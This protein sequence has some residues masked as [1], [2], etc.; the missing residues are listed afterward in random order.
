MDSNRWDRIQSVF[1]G[2]ADLPKSQQRAFLVTACADDESLIADIQ[3]LLDEDAKDSSLLNRKM[4]DVASEVLGDSASRPFPFKEFGPYRIMRVLGE[5][6]MGVVFLAERRDLHSQV[7]IKIL[8]DAWVS[9]ARRERF[10]SEQRT[11]AQLNHPSIAR[12]YDADTLPDGTPL[13]VM[14]Y[15]EGCSIV[16]YCKKLNSSI[17]DRLKLF[18][19]V[20][21]A[22]EYAHSQAVIHRDLKPSNILVKSDG[23]V[24]LLDFGIAKQLED[25]NV[26]ADATRTSFRFLTPAYASPEQIR[27]D[28]VGIQSDVYSLGVILYEL[29]CNQLPFDLSSKTPTEAQAAIL[30]NE[31]VK[32]SFIGQRTASENVA[33]SPGGTGS[34]TKAAWTDLDVLCLTAMHKDPQRRYRSVEALIRDIDHYLRGEP[35]EA[36]PDSVLYRMDKFVGRNR[37]TV[38]ASALVGALIVGLVIF[39]TLRLAKARNAALAETARTLRVEQFMQDLFQGDAES[40]GPADDLRVVTVLERGEKQ[41]RALDEDPEIQA[42][43]YQTLGTM[44]DQLG[45][46]DRADSLLKASLAQ[47]KAIDGADSA[48]VAESLVALANLR[49][50]QAQLAEAE[51]FARQGLQMSKRHLPPDH[52]VVA[53]A[54]LTLGR[55]LDNRGKYDEAIPTLEEAMRLESGPKGVPADL[56]A[57]LS[58]LANTHYYLGHYDVSKDLN[59]RALRMDEQI[60][61]DRNPN[62]AQDL[63]NLADIQYQWSNYA[64]AERLQRTAVGIMQ[65]W[66]GKDH[67]ETADDM[68]ILGKYLIAEGRADEAVPILRESLAALENH[69]G[70]VHPRVALA[71]GELGLALQHQGNLDEAETDFRRQADIY[72]SVYG[73]KNQ[74]LGAAIANLAGVYSDRKDYAKSEELFRGALKLYSD[75]LPAGHLNIA[76]AHVRLGGVLL[77]DKRYSDAEGESRAGYELLMKQSTPP[78]R[79]VETARNDLLAE[80]NAMDQSEK[81]AKIRA[82]LGG[83]SPV[84]NPAKN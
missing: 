64:D 59:E 31:P 29:L 57:T 44:Y 10:S 6:G 76:I 14:E 42:D 33:N 62:V 47:R 79:W 60:Y 39:Y 23:T 36:R 24:R 66:Y 16:D 55:I 22:V 7:A 77:R 84:S 2:A 52:P 48:K 74:Q 18:R 51:T 82:E 68:T 1:H 9:P 3:A 50:D 26:A 12:L 15:V 70:K 38:A 5:G 67:P 73:E 78:A 8:R 46:Y 17:D 80:Y 56:S 19:S 11:L 34:T 32:P 69:Y 65:A 61:G 81:A 53:R 63:T 41:A 71:V 75:S 4:E 13:F 21:E 25:V 27:G 45:K 30:E 28:R 43:L 54:T 49:N 58:E 72:R 83:P 35:L 40:T 37:R 20:C